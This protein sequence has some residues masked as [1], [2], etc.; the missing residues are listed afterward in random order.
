MRLINNRMAFSGV[1]FFP[2]PLF[3]YKFIPYSPSSHLFLTQKKFAVNYFHKLYLNSFEM[4]MQLFNC[5]NFK[6]LN[7]LQQLSI[8]LALKRSTDQ[9]DR[10]WFVNKQEHVN[11]LL[12]LYTYYKWCAISWNHETN[13]CLQWIWI[14]TWHCYMD[15]LIKIIKSKVILQRS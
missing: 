12:L 8:W 4:S 3:T 15:F 14:N 1:A 13:V 11:V 5:T 6:W 2:L 10:V 7:W 9:L